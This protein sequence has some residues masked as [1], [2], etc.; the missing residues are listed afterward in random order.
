[1]GRRF[2]WGRG[3]GTLRVSLT[4]RSYQVPQPS[5]FVRIEGGG[6]VLQTHVGLE[7]VTL[8]VRDACSTRKSVRDTRAALPRMEVRAGS[9]PL[10]PRPRAATFAAWPRGCVNPRRDARVG[11]EMGPRGEKMSVKGLQRTWSTS[12]GVR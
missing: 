12:D 7:P 9:R 6:T 4:R 8:S 10:A 11:A 1:M 3:G 5:T 2:F